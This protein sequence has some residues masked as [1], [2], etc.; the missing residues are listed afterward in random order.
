MTSFS[1]E[2]LTRIRDYLAGRF[3]A[4]V[5][6]DAATVA[7]IRDGSHGLEAYLLRR[8]PSMAFAPGM[9]VFPGGSVDPRDADGRYGWVGPPPAAWA[10]KFGCAEDRARALVCAAARETFEETGVLLAGT[11]ENDAVADTTG[12]RWERDRFQLVEGS[13]SFADF[14]ERRSLVLRAD[15]LRAWSHWIT[16]EWV[17][18][19]YDTR[20]FIATVPAGQETRD[21]GGE[22]DSVAWIPVAEAFAAFADRSLAMMLPTGSTL[23]DLLVYRDAAAAMAAERNITPIMSRPVLV[24]DVLRFVYDTETGPEC[25]DALRQPEASSSP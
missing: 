12:S 20:F 1:D 18:R 7:L 21:V 19:R 17:T 8:R 14:L 22:A 25:V 9:Y 15:L 5:P 2:Q 10:Q 11:G 16:P 3:T 4:A 6:R 23:R 13:L 24:D